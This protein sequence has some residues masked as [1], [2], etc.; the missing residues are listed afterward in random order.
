[1]FEQTPNGYFLNDLIVFNSLREGGYVSKGFVFE[2]PDLTNAQAAELNGFQDQISL[3]LASL[4]E[5]QRL[6]IQFFSDSDYRQELLRYQEETKKATNVWTRRSRN[7]RFERYWEM[8]TE[9]KLRRQRLVFYISRRIE[10]SP[11]GI[12]SKSALT[13]YYEQLLSQLR[14]EFE[15]VHEMLAGIFAGQGARIIPMKDADHYRHYTTFLNPSLA[16]RFDYDPIG[17]FDPQLSIHEN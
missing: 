8:M 2:A 3:M 7:Q 1:M 11:R 12:Q 16:D 14:G 17:G 15:H 9:R 13:E 10:N 5:Q 4:G 6:Q